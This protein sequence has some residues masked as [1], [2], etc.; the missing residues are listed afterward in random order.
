MRARSRP[1]IRRQAQGSDVLRQRTLKESIRATG[2]G[3]HGGEKVYMTLRPAPANAGITFRRV[4]LDSPV[5]ISATA[6]NVTQTTLGTTLEHDNAKVS[7]VEHLLSAMA[8]LG[9]D[10]AYVD[11]TAAEVPIMDGSAAPFIFL[12]QSAGVEEQ[13]A[14]KRFIRIRKPVEVRDGD[15][16][17]RLA[18]YDG[19]RV[20]VEIEFDH[21]V[22]RKHRQTATLEFST[23]AFL[24]EI[25]RARTFGFLRDL[26]TLRDRDLT[27]GG[28]LDNAIVMDEYRV[29]NEDGLRFR[30]EFVRHKILDAVGDLYLLGCCLIGEFTGFKSGHGLNNSLLRALIAQPECYE[31]VV[32]DDARRSPV[33]Y[34]L[35]PALPD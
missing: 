18:P 26:E 3:L 19:F 32:F 4:D 10:N 14:N 2:I 8:A 13:S 17:T 28:G 15:K 5:D 6:L 30:D 33:S 22:L 21:P 35:A 24:K 1:R 9:I 16:W 31:E 20:H 23:T 27:L 34:Q 12:L 25:S 29:L 7:T 11:L